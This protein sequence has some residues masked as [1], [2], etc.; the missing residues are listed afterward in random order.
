MSTYKIT[1]PIKPKA[2][3][4]IRLGRGKAY[5]PNAKGMAAL[6]KYVKKELKGLEG[7]LLSGPLLMIVHFR[8]PLPTSY[9]GI[10]REENHG[11]LHDQ[12]PDG[13]NLEKFLNDSLN[14]ILWE[15]DS[16]ICITFRTKSWTKDNTGDVTIFIRELRGKKPDYQLILDDLLEHYKF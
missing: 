5:N 8:L 4:S 14:K 16:K 7:H 10:K 13:D 15:D 11:N 12:R 6:G 2:K 9:N 1:I 3:A